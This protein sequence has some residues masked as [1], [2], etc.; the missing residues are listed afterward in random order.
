MEKKDLFCKKCYPKV[1]SMFIPDLACS[2]TKSSIYSLVGSNFIISC[3][4]FVFS[5]SLAEFV[6]R[7]WYRYLQET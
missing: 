4:I 1:S 2:S 6:L 5:A 3:K 7:K